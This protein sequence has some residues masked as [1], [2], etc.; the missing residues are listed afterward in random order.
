MSFADHKEVFGRRLNAVEKLDQYLDSLP[1]AERALAIRYLTDL[2]T[3]SAAHIFHEEGY[4]IGR[5]TITRWKK[6]HHV[7]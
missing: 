5:D 3:A 2:G 1:E 4:A 7:I 6:A